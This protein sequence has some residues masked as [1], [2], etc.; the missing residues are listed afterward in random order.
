MNVDLNTITHLQFADD[1]ILFSSTRR[2]DILALK[3]ILRCFQLVSNLKINISK[4][5]LVGIGCSE[6]KD[7][8]RSLANIIHCKS[9]RLLIIYLGLPIGAN[10]RS[11]SLWDPVVDKC[12]RRLSFWKK[13]YLSLGGRI[14]LIKAC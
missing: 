5:L 10:P 12:E 2:E 6:D 9:G 14:T 1:I 11:K 3:R 13:Q 7:T 8:T 4:S